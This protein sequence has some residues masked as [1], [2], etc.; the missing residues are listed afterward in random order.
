LLRPLATVALPGDPRNGRGDDRGRRDGTPGRARLQVRRRG[1]AL[2]RRRAARRDVRAGDPGAVPD[3]ATSRGGNGRLEGTVIT[4]VVQAPESIP[5]SHL[6][7]LGAPHCGVLTTLGPDGF[8]QSSLVWL[9][10]DGSCPTVNTTLQR[11]KSRNLT[12]NPK[13]S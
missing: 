6:D 10:Y 9:D 13:A 11:Q 8:P 3:S 12:A 4:T 7:L 1:G 5:A 2:L